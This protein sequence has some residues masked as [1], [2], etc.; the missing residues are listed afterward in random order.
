MNEQCTVVIPTYNRPKELSRLLNFL[1]ATRESLPIIVLDGSRPDI[2]SS[3]SNL[4]AKFPDVLHQVYDSKL[5]LGI[6]IYRGLKLVKTPYVVICADDDFVFPD[7]VNECVNYLELNKGYSA[8]IG[9]VW[10]LSYYPNKL[11]VSKGVVFGKE[12]SYG[13][14]FDHNLFIQRA[15]FYFSYTAIGSVPLFYSVRRTDQ[16]LQ[17]FS[18]VTSNIK[19]SSMELLS[20]GMLL[21]DG[22]V[23]KLSCP[24]GL[25]DYRSITS[26]DPEREG[27]DEYI[28]ADDRAYL[29]PLMMDSLAKNEGLSLEL[30]DYLISSLL[31]LWEEKPPIV[32]S[33]PTSRIKMKMRSL[34]KYFIC[35]V[36]IA[37]PTLVARY[38]GIS[39]CVYQAVLSSHQRFTAHRSQDLDES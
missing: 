20:T 34:K 32:E 28:P 12:L 13:K 26:R 6:R 9:D 16:T 3:N 31:R 38:L 23:A 18:Y 7:A 21:I 29:K 4:C 35:L 27:N 1:S 33:H 15:L 5:H 37:A 11:I 19:Y 36:S 22:K 8:A 39:P 14:K 17:A 24:F 10:T 30:S 25:R 2:A